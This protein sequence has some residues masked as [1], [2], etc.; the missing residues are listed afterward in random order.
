MLVTGWGKENLAYYILF[1]P[2]V[3]VLRMAFSLSE[4]PK[5]PEVEEEPSFKKLLHVA[6]ECEVGS[7]FFLMLFEGVVAGMA[8]EQV[9]N[10]LGY[11]CLFGILGLPYTWLVVAARR[12]M[13]RAIRMVE[14]PRSR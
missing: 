6:H 13:L 12:R 7:F 14:E 11:L 1:P 3:A 2:L 10:P 9:T 8:E 5:C 4:K